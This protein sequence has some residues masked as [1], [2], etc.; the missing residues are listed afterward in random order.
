MAVGAAIQAGIFQGDVKDVLLLDVIPLSL[1]IE[2]MGA[3]ATKIVERN[4]TIPVSRSQIFST[5]ADN[6]TSVEIHI[7]QGERAMASDN[8]SLGR[9]ILDGIPPS[10]R[11]L[12]QIEVTFDVDASGIL[13]VR[14][15]DKASGKEQSVRIEARSSLT[16]D[17]IEKMK[18]DADLH[19]EED[20]KKREESDMRNLADQLIYTAEKSLR[21]SE[22]KISAEI[23]QGV[24]AKIAE[25]KQVKDKSSGVTEIRTA[26]DALSR[27][28]QKIGE[29]INKTATNETEKK[30]D[31]KGTDSSKPEAG[32]MRDAET[33]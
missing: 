19:A 21:D 27:E 22:G 31:K 18:K 12:P 15:K 6:Q 25:L 28:L 7:V 8:K 17:D 14:A 30:E 29:A 20:K 24:E 23:K 3:V 16:A 10:P 5:A 32:P 11:G 4:T 1:G 26:T 2:T 33:L 9:F 13:N